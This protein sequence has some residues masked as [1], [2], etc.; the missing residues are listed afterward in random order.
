M[1]NILL[2]TKFTISSNLDVSNISKVSNIEITKKNIED[3]DLL[4]QN[5]KVK[6]K[7]IFDIKISKN[8]KSKI[9]LSIQGCNKNF[10][11]LGYLWEKNIL[12]TDSSVG[13]F[14]G[15]KMKS[16]KLIIRGSVENYL[17]SEMEGGLIEVKGNAGDF[18]ASALEGSKTGMR[19]GNILING[20]VG[21]FSCFLMRRGLV[22]IKGNVDENCCFQMIAGTLIIF[23]GVK[24]DLG[25][26]MKRGTIVLIDNSVKLEKK[27]IKSGNINFNFLSLLNNFLKNKFLI[28]ELKKYN[29]VRYFGDKNVN[30][31]GEIFVRENL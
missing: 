23:K 15:A 4:Y 28:N 20:N 8:K 7:D 30:G 5:Q 25:V 31:L 26:S 21:K 29:Y 11:Y 3:I 1:H 19:G 17:G 14:V 12:I 13:S 6:I 9:E 16:G 2:T 24:R 18:L 27:F 22:I 10:Q